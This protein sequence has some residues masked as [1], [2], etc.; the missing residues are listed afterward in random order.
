MHEVYKYSVTNK[1]TIRVIDKATETD[2][3]LREDINKNTKDLQPTCESK[4]EVQNAS[5]YTTAREPNTPEIQPSTEPFSGSGKGNSAGEKSP[6]QSIVVGIVG[7]ALLAGSAVFCALKGRQSFKPL[8]QVI[9]GG[10]FF[11]NIPK[12]LKNKI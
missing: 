9:S 1:D 12:S 6:N 7:T 10:H 3:Q 5:V 8:S 4:E 11:F 2:T